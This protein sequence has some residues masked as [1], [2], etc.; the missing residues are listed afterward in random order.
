MSLTSVFRSRSL[1]TI[2]VA[3]SVSL[4]APALAGD[5]SSAIKGISELPPESQLEI[6]RIVL[7]DMFGTPEEVRVKFVA[8][9][10]KRKTPSSAPPKSAPEKKAD[11][12]L[13]SMMR[14]RVAGASKEA[15]L[16]ALCAAS[17]RPKIEAA[18]VRETLIAKRRA[19]AEA[20]GAK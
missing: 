16:L 19:A 10:D 8:A 20:G 7:D 5:P 17:V 4:S 1:R 14:A 12:S 13:A 6:V 9:C 15:T 3:A 18:L 2:L 11:E